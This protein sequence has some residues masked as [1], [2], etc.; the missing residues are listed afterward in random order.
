VTVA[1]FDVLESL[2]LSE[3]DLQSSSYDL[4]QASASSPLLSIGERKFLFKY[5][6]HSAT[7]SVVFCP[8]VKGMLISWVDC[9]ALG[10]LH[11]AY[12]E[13]LPIGGSLQQD[14]VRTV[15]S[16]LESVASPSLL[17]ADAEKELSSQRR[18]NRST[19]GCIASGE[20]HRWANRNG[21]TSSS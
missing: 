10:I 5:G 12:P 6:P 14:A 20:P 9:I 17:R 11:K 15:N 7:F 4:V 13:P 8:E 21:E 18:R 3:K 1:G 16:S 19:I 2:G